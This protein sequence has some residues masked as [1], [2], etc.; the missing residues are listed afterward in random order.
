M[1]QLPLQPLAQGPPEGW[2]E[3]LRH[4]FNDGDVVFL[5]RAAALPETL[6]GAPQK[7]GRAAKLIRQLL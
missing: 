1:G 6:T 4:D 3:V 2:V 7:A 5:G